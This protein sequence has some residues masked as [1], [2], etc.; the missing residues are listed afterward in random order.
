M[1]LCVSHDSTTLCTCKCAK[2]T[3]HFCEPFI[4]LKR[5][6]SSPY[7]LDLPPD[8]KVYLIFHVSL[9]KELLGSGDNSVSLVTLEDLSSKPQKLETILN[10]SIK[11][12]HFKYIQEFKIKWMDSSIGYLEM[13]RCS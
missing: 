6:G 3:P 10:S 1:F 9:L 2:L 5:I 11:G 8:I 7:H 13:R 4:V 12:L